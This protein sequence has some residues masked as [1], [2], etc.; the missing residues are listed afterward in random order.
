FVRVELVEPR[1]R[2]SGELVLRDFLVAVLVRLRHHLRGNKHARSKTATAATAATAAR[3]ARTTRSTFWGHRRFLVDLC[4][5]DQQ[6]TLFALAGNDDLAV[7]TA[8]EHGFKAVEAQI[9][10]LPFFAV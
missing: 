1:I 7:L 2:Q 6:Q 4:H 5:G 8:F 3:T 9:A 10:L